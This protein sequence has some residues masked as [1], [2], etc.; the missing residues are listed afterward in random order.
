MKIKVCP[1]CGHINPHNSLDCEKCG[2]NLNDVLPTD[3][4][5]IIE[6]PHSA[7]TSV[8]EI[9]VAVSVTPKSADKK[10]KVFRVCPKCG[11]HVQPNT[12]RCE[13]GQMLHGIPL[14]A[15]E[16]VAPSV[17]KLPSACF[18][19]RSEDG[20]LTIHI[21]GD[22]TVTIGREATGAD[23]LANKLYVGRRHL[24][25]NVRDGLVYITDISSTNPTLVNGIA[26]KKDTPY[27]LSE[28]DLVS[29]G[30]REKQAPV[31]NAAY[32]RLIRED[33]KHE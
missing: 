20:R 7:E 13:C 15:S 31:E 21:P 16:N 2:Q 24:Q 10:P 28:N 19:F 18:M 12:Y 8:P 5:I 17:N 29:L 11:N 22:E 25:V 9:H 32:F 23:Y 3:D 1:D 6:Q 33:G 26:L 4:S 30:A 27:K 14:T